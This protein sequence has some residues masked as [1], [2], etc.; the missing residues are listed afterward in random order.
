MIALVAVDPQ[1]VQYCVC[2]ALA[3]GKFMESNQISAQR[4]LHISISECSAVERVF[5]NLVSCSLIY[6]NKSDTQFL[7]NFLSGLK[8]ETLSSPL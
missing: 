2:P 7:R 1:V 3:V 8:A 5:C 6:E 4:Q